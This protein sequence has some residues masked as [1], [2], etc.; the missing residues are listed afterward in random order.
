IAA[1][2]WANHSLRAS[3]TA[4]RETLAVIHQEKGLHNVEDKVASVQEIFTLQGM[5]ELKEAEAKYTGSNKTVKGIILAA[6]QGKELGNLTEKI[7]KTLLPLHH[8]T[9]L[10]SIVEGMNQVNITDITVVRGFQK[11]MIT[12]DQFRTVDNPDFNTTQDLYSLY[13]AKDNLTDAVMITYGDNAFRKHV[14]NSLLESDGDIK[15]VV[16]ADPSST[17]SHDRVICSQPY[18]NDFFN[19]DIFVNDIHHSESDAQ[20]HGVWPGILMVEKNKIA[21][22]KEALDILSQQPD[23]KKLSVVDLIQYL[24]QKDKVQVVYT[25]G[26]W[27]G[28]NDLEDFKEA[29]QF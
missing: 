18:S 16:D 15:I 28:V 6:G 14:L 17:K 20:T 3:I 4:M 19:Q 21:V 11:D 27:V 8:N 23:F 24:S 25:K 22:L 29:S 12:G 13:L 1:V 7:P 9:I 26:G 10:G 2:I 5:E